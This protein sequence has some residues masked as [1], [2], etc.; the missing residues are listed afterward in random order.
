MPADITAKKAISVMIYGQ[1]SIGKTTLACSASNAVLF[2]YDGGVDRINPAH[3]VPTLQ[4]ESWEDTSNALAQLD[5]DPL[6]RGTRTI[7]I[8]TVGKMLDYMS[9]S[10]IRT[11]PKMADYYGNLTLKGYGQRKKMFADFVRKLKTSG[12]NVVFIAHEKED[13]DGD[14]RIIRPLVGG[15]SAADLAQELDL[16]GYMY[17]RG[18]GRLLCFKTNDGYYTK[19]SYQ[20]EDMVVPECVGANGVP[21][22]ANDFLE[23]EV[24]GAYRAAMARKADLLKRYNTLIEDINDIIANVDTIDALNDAVKAIKSLDLIWDA[25]IKANAVISAKAATLGAKYDKDSKAY[26]AA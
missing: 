17:S 25:P 24:F 5:T 12:R 18:N 2:D 19:N 26:V 23:R 11:N 21:T 7:I 1:P 22:R 4:V 15:S 6:L 3:T 16:M 20:L 10:I 14:N 9:E 13:K 8:D